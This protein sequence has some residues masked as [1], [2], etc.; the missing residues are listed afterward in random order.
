[1]GGECPMIEAEATVK[2][3]Q[4]RKYWLTKTHVYDNLTDWHGVLHALFCMKYD[5]DSSVLSSLFSQRKGRQGFFCCCTSH[6][7]VEPQSLL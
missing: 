7:R 6:V 4:G 5:D 1:M 3:E 2:R